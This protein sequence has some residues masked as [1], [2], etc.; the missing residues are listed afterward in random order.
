MAVTE[1]YIPHEHKVLQS[2]LH[3]AMRTAMSETQDKLQTRKECLQ[4]IHLQP[5]GHLL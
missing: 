1:W 4:A 3:V 5:D 2:A